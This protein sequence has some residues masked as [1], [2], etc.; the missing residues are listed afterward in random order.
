[1]LWLAWRQFRSQ[2]V[3]AGA[4]LA[5]AAIALALTGV[6]LAALYRDSG[7]ATCTTA[8]GQPTAAFTYDVRSSGGQAIFYAGVVVLYL[9][10]ALAGIF[11]GAPLI[12]R[13]FESGTLSLAWNQSV[14]RT[15]WAVVKLG[16][17]GLA[18]LAASGLLSLMLT[19]WSRPIYA[20]AA[21]ANNPS[22]PFGRIS[23][24]YFGAG[25]IVPA[26]YAVFAFAL[27]VSVGVLVR[28]T[29]PAMALTLAV[30]AAVQV[31][32]PMLIRPHLAPPVRTTYALAAVSFSATGDSNGR[33]I[34]AAAELPGQRGGWILS[35]RPVDT[36]G[37][38]VTQAPQACNAQPAAFL[39]CLSGRGIRLSITYQP[40]SRYWEF[41]WI[42]TGIF[43][44]LATG[45][46]GLCYLRVRRPS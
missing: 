19:L 24:L 37:H 38:V 27:G 11:W 2:A 43:L 35:Q 21:K 8:C 28:R 44:V 32:M 9:I 4:A 34:L 41:Q 40:A 33:L 13:E 18:A 30:F 26:G 3:V 39:Q 10:P 17:V 12:T 46:G 36:R 5:A 45:L 20:A 25:G 14:P 31:L 6:H 16:F 42:E 23:P 15:R 7:L 29:I 22:L 1:M